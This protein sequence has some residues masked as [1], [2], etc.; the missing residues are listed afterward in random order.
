M[1]H[2]REYLVSVTAAA[3]LCGVIRCFT[4]D[5]GIV[6]LLSGIFLVLTV[7]RPVSDISLDDLSWAGLEIMDDA[8]YAVS[9]G[10]D[11][12]DAAMARHIKDRCEAYI[13]DK[14][15]SFGIR[16]S[17]EFTLNDEMMP[18][19]CIIRGE[20]SSYARQQLSQIL[21]SDLGVPREAQQWNP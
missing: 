20:V 1:E 10:E 13:L 8:D 17:A 4:G 21:Q 18:A 3:L 14:A 12:A 19:G 7:I 2:I 16:I 9:E 15:E 11:Y 5:K 6:P